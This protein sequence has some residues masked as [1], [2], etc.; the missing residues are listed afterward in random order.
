M[1]YY[2]FVLKNNSQNIPSYERTCGT[3]E[4]AKKRV[5]ELE[6]RKGTIAAFYTVDSLPTKFWY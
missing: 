5:K 6:K 2:V 3:K 4:G 1:H